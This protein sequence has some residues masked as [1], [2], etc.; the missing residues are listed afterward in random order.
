MWLLALQVAAVLAA[1]LLDR[2][3]RLGRPVPHQV[4]R[5]FRWVVVAIVL[6]HVVPEGWE[7][8]GPLAPLALFV[9]FGLAHGAERLTGAHQGLAVMGAAMAFH[10][11]F[12]GF[13]LGQPAHGAWLA[14]AIVLHT[15]PVA[16]LAWR[17]AAARSTAA[18]AG[19]LASLVA[20]TVAG[21]ALARGGAAPSDAAAALFACFVGG[22]LAQ[23]LGHGHGEGDRSS[24]ESHDKPAAYASRTDLSASTSSSP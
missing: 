7:A 15:L 6:S 17:L 20:A 10:H 14:P 13:A 24:A 2:A 16:L 8:A 9:G 19:M 1:P 22:W 23:A 18:G 3:A 5:W 21:F 12:D 11:L 4:H